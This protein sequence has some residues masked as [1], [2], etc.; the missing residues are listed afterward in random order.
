ML[1]FGSSVISNKLFIE[2]RSCRNGSVLDLR[3]EEDKEGKMSQ[4]KPVLAN[5]SHNR[6]PIEGDGGNNL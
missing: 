4:G 2:S 6:P 1:C 3:G 5:R